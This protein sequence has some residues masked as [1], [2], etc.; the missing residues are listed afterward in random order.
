VSAHTTLVTGAT[1]NLG[2]AVV[3]E[4][5]I[6]GLPVRA[7]GTD[8]DRLERE[9][10]GVEAARLDLTDP[11]TF[12]PTLQGVRRLFLVRPPA[13]TRVKP[14]VNRFLDVAADAGVQHVV[15]SSVLGAEANRIVPHHRIETHLRS[16]ALSWTVLRPGFFAQNL[17]TAYARDIVDDDRIHLPAADGRVAFID[18]RDIGAIAADILADPAK[19]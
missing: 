19:H 3:A 17:A 1:G 12:S 4:L 18:T 6:R 2:S 9:F 14:T 5:Q 7:A 15:F 13:I 10:P 11:T 16:L 8:T